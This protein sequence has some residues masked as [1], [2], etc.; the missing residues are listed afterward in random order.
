[1]I[2]SSSCLQYCRIR[3]FGTE[4]KNNNLFFVRPKMFETLMNHCY[5]T[6]VRKLGGKLFLIIKYLLVQ[7]RKNHL[8]F[9]K[10]KAR[11]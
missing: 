6:V 1:M 7:G 5:L 3:E 11:V 8:M 9:L 10:E 2:I 4:M